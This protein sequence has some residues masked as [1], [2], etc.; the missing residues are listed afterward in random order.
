M[1]DEKKVESKFQPGDVVAHRTTSFKKMVVITHR[2]AEGLPQ[3]YTCRYAYNGNYVKD[4][5]AEIE[6]EKYAAP[7]VNPLRSLRE[8]S[9]REG[10]ADSST[11][12]E[13]SQA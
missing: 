1:S 11:E 6:I 2:G 12:N 4:D 5:F 3:M 9:L 10:E 13:A 7:I 8:R